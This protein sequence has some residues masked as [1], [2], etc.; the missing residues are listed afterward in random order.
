MSNILTE[1]SN[2]IL[3]I[4]INRPDKLNALNQKT[5]A[6]LEQAIINSQDDANI[7]A[8]IITGNGEKSFIA[9]ADIS[10]LARSNAI[11]GMKF[12]LYGQKV[13]NTIEQSIKP[14][15]AAINGFALGGGCELAMS[16]HMRIAADNAM[17]GQPEIKLGVI[18]G[19]GGTQRLV[20][21]IG[22]GRAMEMNLMGGM[23]DAQ[24]AYEIGLVNSVVAQTELISHVEKMAKQLTF[25]APVALQCIID[26]INYGAE[27]SLTEGLQFEAKAFAVTC[28]TQDMQE[29]TTAFLEK[30]PA[31]FKGC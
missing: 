17:F 16:C 30:R 7:A 12:A 22:K 1:V 31:N 24:R 20:R 28:A 26:S 15:I 21:L 11:T 5:L 10:E 3:T 2:K 19:F 27:C 6:E 14:V 8:I 9:G 25:A 23:I 13:M 29:G 18:P 4:T